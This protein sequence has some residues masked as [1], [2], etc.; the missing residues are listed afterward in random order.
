MVPATKAMIDKLEH[1][2]V[3]AREKHFGKAA[4]ACNISQRTLSASIKHLE[5]QLGELS[6]EVDAARVSAREIAGR[7]VAEEGLRGLDPRVRYPRLGSED[8]RSLVEGMSP[9]Q[10][11]AL[12][13]LSLLLKPGGKL[14]I[15]HFISSAEI[16]DVHRKAG[17][18]VA[19]DMIPSAET[20]RRWCERCNLSIG[21]WQDDGEGYLLS[22]K[23]V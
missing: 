12:A 10:A 23:Q 15:S 20:L 9:D 16:N 6:L 7:E 22:A 4:E 13:A 14:V 2:L 19:E 17:T 5:D 8:V 11:A 18:A 21:T 1:F 3:L